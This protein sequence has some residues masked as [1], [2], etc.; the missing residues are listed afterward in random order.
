MKFIGNLFSKNILK[1]V[2]FYFFFVVNTVS[3]F[4]QSNNPFIGKWETEDKSV[5]LNF[6][7]NGEIIIDNYNL[8]IKEIDKRTNE[9]TS[10][11]VKCSG[12]GV[13]K[14]NLTYLNIS[15][16]LISDE[17]KTYTISYEGRYKIL[18]NKLSFLDSNNKVLVSAI[19][20]WNS[21]SDTG[22]LRSVS[23]YPTDE[24]R[25]FLKK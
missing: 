25:E 2:V 24:Y 4:S 10:R 19:T 16:R 8:Y 17:N 7:I 15:L 6:T 23:S 13:Y 3:I 22:E 14:F 21:Y 5:V 18:N 1:F 12:L 9:E 20:Y 11:I